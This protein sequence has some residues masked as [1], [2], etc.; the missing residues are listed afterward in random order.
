MPSEVGAVAIGCD[1]RAID[2]ITAI[3]EHLRG[4]GWEVAVHAPASGDDSVDY[5]EPAFAAA[6]AVASGAADR[7]VLVCGSG[8]GMSMAANK[9]DGVRAALAHEAHAAQMSRRHNDANILCMA[10]DG[11]AQIDP[12]AIVDAWLAA[13]FEGGRHQ[14]RVDKIT[15]IE[16]GVDPAGA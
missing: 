9:V 3:A 6:S 11:K 5:P 15:S 13:D 16:R 2:I 14:R 8:I 7:G 12:I 4:A 1:H 10:A